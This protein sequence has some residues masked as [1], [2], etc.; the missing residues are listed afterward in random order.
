[1]LKKLF[2]VCAWWLMGLSVQAQ[3]QVFK[4]CAQG[5][6]RVESSDLAFEQTVLQLVN[7][8]RQK[9]KLPALKMSVALTN[10]A[11]YHAYDMAT[12]DYFHHDSYDGKKR[13]CG[14]FDRLRK[15]AKAEGFLSL[16][17]NIAAGQADAKSVFATW[18]A[19]TGHRTN[20]LNK[21]YTHIGIAFIRRE[22]SE[23]G[24]YWV[25]CFGTK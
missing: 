8:E 6:E 20:I 17:E 12:D 4:G 25:Q 23:Y 10:S 7:A 11:R 24:T 13:Q 1:M 18:M 19:S 21:K 22:G 16:A 15:F 9:R 5:T 14:T 3:T 2:V